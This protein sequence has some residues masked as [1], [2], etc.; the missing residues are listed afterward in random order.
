MVN[1]GGDGKQQ[2]EIEEEH[3]PGSSCQNIELLAR[4]NS[5]TWGRLS[6][7]DRDRIVANGP[8]PNPK[9]FPRDQTCR[10]FPTSLL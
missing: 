2:N 9:E 1:K 4:R 10:V 6:K 7:G 3:V 8:L 5:A